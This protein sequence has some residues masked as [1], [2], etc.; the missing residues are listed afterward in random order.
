MNQAIEAEKGGRILVQ[1]RFKPELHERIARAADAADVPLSTFI[2]LAVLHVLT[3]A[4]R[5]RQ[6]KRKHA[7]TKG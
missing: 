2:R 6:D 7:A 5:P 4:F 3:R 1:I